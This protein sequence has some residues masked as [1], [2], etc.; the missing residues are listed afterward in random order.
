MPI[1]LLAST[2]SACSSAFVAV[3]YAHLLIFFIF[4]SFQFLFDLSKSLCM[5]ICFYLSFS[6]TSSFF[7]QVLI[8]IPL[9]CPFL[10]SFAVL[11]HQY[12]TNPFSDLCNPFIWS[13]YIFHTSTFFLTLNIFTIFIQFFGI[14]SLKIFSNIPLFS[15]IFFSLSFSSYFLGFNLKK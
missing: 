4:L 12:S 2:W 9:F 10:I 7:L 11:C 3:H 13:K 5:A 15:S 8:F 14:Q 1:T 6:L